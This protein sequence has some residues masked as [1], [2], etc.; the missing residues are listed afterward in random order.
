MFDTKNYFDP[1][2][3]SLP[4]VLIIETQA[5]MDKIEAIA[6]VPGVEALFLAFFA[7]CFPLGLDPMKQPPAQVNGITERMLAI[8][9]KSDAAMGIYVMNLDHPIKRQSQSFRSISY[10]IDYMMLA[11]LTRIGLSAFRRGTQGLDGY[12]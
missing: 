9:S 12:K 8:G 3:D 7:L 5:A 4:L 6:A 10:R 11:D 2:T 1:T